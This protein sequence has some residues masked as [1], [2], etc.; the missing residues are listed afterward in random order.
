MKQATRDGGTATP[1]GQAP[2]VEWL[3]FAFSIVTR[4]LR[5]DI[6]RAHF[7]E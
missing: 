6:E 5:I 7:I 3:K 1:V 2:P 4:R